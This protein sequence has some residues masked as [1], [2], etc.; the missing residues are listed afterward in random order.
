MVTLPKITLRD[1]PKQIGNLIDVED[2]ASP[3][4]VSFQEKPSWM[5]EQ[6]MAD[7]RARALDRY[8][9]KA[10]PAFE[11]LRTF[12][13]KEYI[14]KSRTDIAWRSMPHGRDWYLSNVKHHTTTDLTPDQIF[15]IGMSEVKRIRGKMDSIR[16]AIGYNG[17]LQEFLNF[18][19]SDKQFFYTDS[20]SLIH[21]YMVIAKKADAELTKLFK[22]LP[23]TPY[24][25]V[26][27]PSY[28]QASQTTAYYNQGSLNL[29]RPGLFYANT[30]D[31]PSRPK[32]EM[33]ALTLH[34]AVPGHHLQIAIAQE[35]DDVPE[36]RK[37][38]GYTAYVEGWG[39]YA[40]A[41]GEEMGFYKDPYTKMG[42]LTYEMWR[43]IRLVVD[44]G[45]HWKNWTRE[46]A[47]Q[48]FEENAGKA[49][50][51]IEVEVDR[52]IVW[53]GQA[54]AYKIGELKIKELRGYAEKEL[55]KA[56][57]IRQFHDVILGA[58]ALPLNILETRVKNWVRAQRM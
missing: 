31:L 5:S 7:L 20:A 10:K 13:E 42:Q 35:L 28:A 52:Y 21:G 38:E 33:E 6:A 36:L 49:S 22:T 8:R 44:V 29:G 19:R 55:G 15:D 17:T 41:L 50:H 11:Q 4:L 46:Q 56:F 23:R 45:M 57:D 53:P 27:V 12:L 39:L 58:G 26:P 18:M 14:P 47:I 9:T 48:F 43:S 37:E 51:D 1:V 40:E 30:Y 54:L 2:R 16:K 24:G 34:E 32:W 3:L 25:V